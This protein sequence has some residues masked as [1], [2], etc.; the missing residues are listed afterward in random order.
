MNTFVRTI[1]KYGGDAESFLNF[2]SDVPELLPYATILSARSAGDSDLA[3]LTGV[4]EWQDTPL[5]FLVDGN[6]LQNDQNRLNR[7][8]RLL[9]MRG[10]T[11]YLGIV[12]PGQLTFYRVSLDKNTPDNSR[13]N[14]NIPSGG[15]RTTFAYLGNERPGAETRR[16]ISDVVLKLLTTSIQ[17]LIETIGVTKNDAISLVGRALFAR[18]LA[19][20]E[21]LPDSRGSAEA[22][23]DN[24]RQATKTSK[25]LDDTFNGDFL[26]L[27]EN[28][29][30]Q[31]PQGA[32]GT[33][34]DIMRRA[35]EGQLFLGWQEKWDRLDF[36]HIPVGVLSQ[37]YEAYLKK[38]ARVKQRKEGGYYTPSH[39]AN[40]M[41]RGAFHAMRRDGVAHNARILDPAAGAGVF[42]LTAFRQLVAERW[43]HDQKR[44]GTRTLREILY[45]QITGF[46]INESAL[47]FSA[48]G[49][50]LISI[51]LDKNPHPVQKLRFEKLRERV[52]HDFSDGTNNEESRSL[53]SLGDKVGK[54]HIGKYDLVIGNPPWTS[55]TNLPNWDEVKRTIWRIA[56]TR[57]PNQNLRPPSPNEGPDLPFVWRA[58]EWA[59]PN[60]QI[61]F[62]L[63]GRL[64]FQQGDN[65]PA[66]RSGL[67]RALDITGI[68]NGADLRQTEVWPKIH[69][70]F[71][72]LFAR[73]NVPIPGNGFRFISPRLE[74]HLNGSGGFRIDA[75]N[76]ELIAN[77][78][79][80]E[81]PKILK[82]LYRGSQLDLEIFERLIK[83]KL[84]TFGEFWKESFG[85]CG[86]RLRHAGN[87][88]KLPRGTRKDLKSAEHLRGMRN[89]AAGGFSSLLI[90]T[91]TLPHFNQP[92]LHRA[93][94]P[95]IYKGP[96]LIVHKSPPAGE[97]RI[98]VGVAEDDL[99]F[100]ETYY[101]Y[102]TRT[103]AQ[104][105]LLAR[106]LALVLSSKIA[107]WYALITS[108]ELGFERE[109]IE[110][111]IIE[112]IPFPQFDLLDRSNL[113]QID[114][115]F[116]AIVK[117]NDKKTWTKIDNW[118]ASLYGF[119]KSDLQTITDT[120][121]FNL[122]FTQ[123]K[124][125]AQGIPTENEIDAFCET[126]CE[127]LTPW[128]KRF[129]SIV[130]IIRAPTPRASPWQ[131]IRVDFQK[132]STKEVAEISQSDWSGMFKIADRI[133][134]TEIIHPELDKKYLWVG[135]LNQARY[136]TRSQARLVARRVIW[137][138]IDI[139]AGN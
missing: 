37:A 78:Q 81:N 26:P 50:Y 44:P 4:Y 5:V 129:S 60:G 133:A 3:A 139:F 70:P 74:H 83:K 108:G 53:G 19:D 47:R 123:N 24:P 89:L 85:S 115:F 120:L 32:L 71:C 93:R 48:L 92:Y 17:T 72:L 57:L 65:M 69:A 130:K 107:L 112:G 114:S 121:R 110:K 64:L 103:H 15:E 77:Q 127:E 14:L 67:F 101:G 18:F 86:R 119:Q 104:S 63:H 95:E 59:K 55:S 84:P 58:M 46:D 138:H 20:R 111:I 106:Y 42:L 88:Y 54:S 34:G 118:I 100:S 7:L 40:V 35:P 68:I 105:K 61:A 49:L 135:R 66:A 11:P 22:L 102:S 76:A 94:D 52:L 36:S 6:E 25:W 137:N 91:S 131:A 122:P 125:Y 99:V 79:V 1:Q 98:H 97:E 12:F 30:Y 9:A 51:E 90:D 80:I 128:A 31:L 82:I 10:D 73:N 75:Y 21:L 43:R 23:F 134:A 41:V 27:T 39:I 2:D 136:W 56:G 62:A 38:H 87:G 8:R 33:L 132:R 124:D 28:I 113:E 109:V 29:F 13:I 45:N 126:L 96:I 116:D 117:N 16:W